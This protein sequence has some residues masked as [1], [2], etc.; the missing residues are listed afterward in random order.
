MTSAQC[1]YFGHRALHLA[2]ATQQT[3]ATP[4][5]LAAGVRLSIAHGALVLKQE[6]LVDGVIVAHVHRLTAS[7]SASDGAE[8]C[9][10]LVALQWAL[11]R[12]GSVGHP[13]WL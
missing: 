2:M 4:W 9:V 7:L 11:S 8:P 13:A 5:P 6:H 10:A 3:R 12:H 1:V